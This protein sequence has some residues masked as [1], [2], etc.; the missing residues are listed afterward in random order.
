[1]IN[2][3]QKQFERLKCDQAKCT[4]LKGIKSEQKVS[5]LLK[6]Y[7]IGMHMIL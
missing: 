6:L 7:L 1:M 3:V 5:K 4:A 2:D